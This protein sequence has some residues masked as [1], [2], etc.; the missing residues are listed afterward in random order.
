MLVACVHHGGNVYCVSILVIVHMTVLAFIFTT[1][2]QG[3][4]HMANLPLMER[5]KNEESEM[6]NYK[7]SAH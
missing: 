3:K 6:K 2:P 7:R 5:W 1:G 4:L